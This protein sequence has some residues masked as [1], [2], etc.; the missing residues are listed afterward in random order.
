MVDIEFLG[1]H[2]KSVERKD[3]EAERGRD[4][5][6]KGEDADGASFFRNLILLRWCGWVLISYQSGVS[7]NG[8]S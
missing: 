2:T 5:R 6:I 7:F 4:P 8:H 3:R 1:I